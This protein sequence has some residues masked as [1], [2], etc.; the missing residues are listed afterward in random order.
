MANSDLRPK[1]KS[2]PDFSKRS[3]PSSLKH[4]KNYGQS[5]D[6]DRR[7][8]FARTR[9]L[10]EC[11]G[12]SDETSETP[13]AKDNHSH[14]CRVR[15]FKNTRKGL[16][17]AGESYKAKDAVG[18]F[19]RTGSVRCYRKSVGRSESEDSTDSHT[20]D[21]VG[22]SSLAESYYRVGVLG[23][24]GVGKTTLVRQF[25]ASDEQ[26]GKENVGEVDR[27]LKKNTVSVLLDGDESLLE[28]LDDCEGEDLSLYPD[29][30]AHPNDRDGD[31]PSQSDVTPFQCDAYTVVFALNDVC[32]LREG[33]LTLCHLREDLG[34]DRAIFLVGNK[35][36]LVRQRH[37]SVED[38]C[39]LAHKY[40]CK[41]IETSAELGHRTDELLVGILRHIRRRLS[42]SARLESDV[43]DDVKS[44]DKKRH[45]WKKFSVFYRF[46]HKTS[47]ATDFCQDVF[48]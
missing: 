39:K 16:V 1:E 46:L 28:F 33:D 25:L 34:C 2:E 43:E 4:R 21:S 3:R 24:A 8:V 29:A 23:G 26:R 40:D 22:G 35:S 12:E 36:D 10:P 7:V 17:R 9:S 37:V 14:F 15:S 11:G 42:T 6:N 45:K 20:A 31:C 47:N 48:L 30:Y 19:K 18:A 44:A 32:S 38:A 27:D 13:D 41:Y 5:C